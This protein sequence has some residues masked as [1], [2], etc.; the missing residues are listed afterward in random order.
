MSKERSVNDVVGNL[1]NMLVSIAKR[2]DEGE[3][4]KAIEIMEEGWAKMDEVLGNTWF[5]KEI[6]KIWRENHKND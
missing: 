5:N 1:T 6:G 2:G 3:I 4:K